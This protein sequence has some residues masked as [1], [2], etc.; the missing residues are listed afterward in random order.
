MF[1]LTE[2][3][4]IQVEE[5]TTEGATGGEHLAESN[6]DV[7]ENTQTFVIGAVEHDKSNLMDQNRKIAEMINDTRISS[8]ETYVVRPS[9]DFADENDPFYLEMHFPDLFPF[10]KAGFREF[11]KPPISKKA[12]MRYYLN[13]STRQFQKPDFLFPVHNLLVRQEIANEVFFRARLPSKHYTAMEST[14]LKVKRFRKFR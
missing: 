8:D 1:Q 11:R 2:E 14:Y 4:P 13:L 10:G 3:S 5:S 9:T 7:G 12:L 6:E